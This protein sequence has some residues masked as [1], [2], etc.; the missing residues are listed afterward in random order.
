MFLDHG[1]EGLATLGPASPPPFPPI[2]AALTERANANMDACR[3]R[4]AAKVEAGRELTLEDCIR[5]TEEVDREAAS[6]LAN[7]APNC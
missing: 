2:D 4:I 6:S 5:I 7:T 1:V 3:E